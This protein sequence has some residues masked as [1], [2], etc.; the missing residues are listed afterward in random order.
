MV[1]LF[2]G[3]HGNP[4]R[5]L[6]KYTKRKRDEFEENGVILIPE[7]LMENMNN[8]YLTLLKDSRLTSQAKWKPRLLHCKH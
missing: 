5:K 2:K 8:K 4:N 6:T 1:A 3:Y 7:T